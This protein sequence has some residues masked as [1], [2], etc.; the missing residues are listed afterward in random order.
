V[1]VPGA[2]AQAADASSVFLSVGGTSGAAQAKHLRQRHGICDCDSLRADEAHVDVFA[3][4]SLCEL[5]Q[6]PRIFSR[7]E[8]FQLHVGL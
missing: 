6:S 5:H 2:G 8:E 3:P 7:R 4:A 1:Y